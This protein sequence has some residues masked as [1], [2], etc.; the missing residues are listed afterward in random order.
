MIYDIEF[1][2]KMYTKRAS[3]TRSDWNDISL[4]IRL[5]VVTIIPKLIKSAILCC[6]EPHQTA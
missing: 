2:S 3:N 5:L 6:F 4:I 1:V